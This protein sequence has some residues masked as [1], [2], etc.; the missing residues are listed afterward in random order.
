MCP[1]KGQSLMKS[2]HPQ[3]LKR[4]VLLAVKSSPIPLTPRMILT[5]VN[6]AGHVDGIS[7]GAIDQ[8]ARMLALNGEIVESIGPDGPVYESILHAH[9]R[10]IHAPFD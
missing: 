4:E 2:K 5:A 7:A 6:R 10:R 9:M 1:Q 8:V 3:D